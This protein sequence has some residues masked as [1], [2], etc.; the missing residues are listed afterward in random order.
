MGH[1]ESPSL[2]SLGLAADDPQ[3]GSSFRWGLATSGLLHALVIILAVFLRFQ[4]T[5]E[6]PFRAIDV[7]LISLPEAKT[8]ATNQQK[9]PPPA[10]TPQKPQPIK[11]KPIK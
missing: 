1:A 3:E 7:T 4:S 8:P 9:S 2:I 6:E 5:V 11:A 10:P